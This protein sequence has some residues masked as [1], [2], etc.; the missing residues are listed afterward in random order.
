M[1]LCSWDILEK[2]TGPDCWFCNGQNRK[3]KVLLTDHYILTI[4]MIVIGYTDFSLK[5]GYGHERY[6]IFYVFNPKHK[7]S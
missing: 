3:K 1:L 7:M 6:P 2:G 4:D 5:R